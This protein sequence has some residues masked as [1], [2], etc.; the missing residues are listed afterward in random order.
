MVIIVGLNAC[1]HKPILAG[2][3]LESV[4]GLADSSSES[5]DSE[6]PP[7]LST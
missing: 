1:D 4:I 6:C 7:N 2:W 5:A 3:A